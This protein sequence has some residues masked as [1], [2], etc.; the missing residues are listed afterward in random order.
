MN[1]LSKA[2]DILLDRGKG[3]LIRKGTNF[4]VITPGYTDVIYEDEENCNN[5]QDDSVLMEV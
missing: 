4:I 1:G 3:K 5:F 2:I